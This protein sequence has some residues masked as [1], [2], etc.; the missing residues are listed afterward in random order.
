MNTF[1]KQLLA[2]T[3][4]IIA[5]TQSSI[6]IAT[7][8]I[9]TKLPNSIQFLDAVRKGDL[10]RAHS[11]VTEPLIAMGKI[12]YQNLNLTKED[13]FKQQ[14]NRVF[15]PE[16]I[17]SLLNRLPTRLGSVGAVKN[18]ETSWYNILPSGAFI[19]II[20]SNTGAPKSIYYSHLI[21]PSFDCR[22]AKSLTENLLC[23]DLNLSRWDNRFA[24]AYVNAKKYLTGKEYE[25]LQP[26]QQA[27][28]AARD[29]CKTNKSCIESVYKKR[30]TTLEDQVA[31]EANKPPIKFNELG[32][33]NNIW[34]STAWTAA[35]NC[36]NAKTLKRAESTQ[37]NMTINYPYVIVKSQY[38]N[39]VKMAACVIKS[40]DS[41]TYSQF[42]QQHFNRLKG[43]DKYWGACGGDMSKLN[44]E[45]Y[46]IYMPLELA[47]SEKGSDLC[48]Q[49][50]I[51]VTGR[52]DNY[53]FIYTEQS[54]S[55]NFVDSGF[56]ME[57]H[58]TGH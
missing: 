10:D 39:K 23:S 16:I 53:Q 5:F 14:F 47:H 17:N 19:Q 9:N 1:T 8:N 25:S 32:A 57:N 52:P 50:A 31:F 12:T 3:L 54:T 13:D 41:K 15:A 6:S 48:S 34:Q 56:I 30:V 38:K 51:V 29:K 33:I 45:G 55:G 37:V 26:K 35:S 11:F 18:K 43:N 58:L 46:Y 36:Q 27:F 40:V 49:S 2:T 24:M 28:I 7:P 22:K 4:V 44:Y 20:F 42:E 21:A